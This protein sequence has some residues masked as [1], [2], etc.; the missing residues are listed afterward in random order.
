MRVGPEG[1]TRQLDGYGHLVI[2]AFPSL[3]AVTLSWV[4]VRWTRRLIFYLVL[5][6]V[7]LRRHRVLKVFSG[8]MTMTMAAA[9]SRAKDS[10]NVGLKRWDCSSSP[11]S[12]TLP[13]RAL[14][15]ASLRPTYI[16]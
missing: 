8:F 10:L 12:I 15:L 7:H 14:S 16:R 5:D 13:K 9:P 3:S 11:R 4:F 2:N 6:F 1:R